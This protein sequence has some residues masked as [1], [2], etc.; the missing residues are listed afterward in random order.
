MRVCVGG[1]G[2]HQQ[3]RSQVYGRE[4]HAFPIILYVCASKTNMP[5]AVRNGV[6]RTFSWCEEECSLVGAI[7][8]ILLDGTV[9]L[10]FWYIS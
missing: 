7:D 2:N 8:I 5:V 4:A 1:G 10:G 9:A 6:R 3:G